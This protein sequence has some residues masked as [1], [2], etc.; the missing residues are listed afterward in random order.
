MLE[1]RPGKIVLESGTGS[2][3]LSMALARTIA[4]TGHLYTYEFHEKRAQ[5]ARYGGTYRD[6]VL[7]TAVTNL[8]CN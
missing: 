4:P 8:E 3:S 5:S 6:S 2:G 7:H 1:L